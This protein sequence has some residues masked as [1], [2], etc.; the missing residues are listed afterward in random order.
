MYT[1]Q[2]DWEAHYKKVEAMIGEFAAK[3]GKVGG[4]AQ[5]LLE[6]LKL[7]DQIN[8]QLEKVAVFASLR[9]DEDM[10]VSAN[11]ALYQRMQTLRVK[12]GESASWFQPEVLKIPE[13]KLRDWLKQPDLQVYDHY[14]HDLLRSKAHILSAREEE[15]L[16]KSGRAAD[17]SSDVFGLLSNTELRWRTVKDPEGKDVDVLSLADDGV[18]L[19]GRDHEQRLGRRFRR[20]HPVVGDGEDVVARPVIV[21]DEELRAELAVRVRRVRVQSAAEPVAGGGEW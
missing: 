2:E 10:R 14:F 9:R 3:N 11:H 18:Q 8:I 19:G 17:T 16:A 4:S 5:S 15:L 13:D 6:A 12:W 20:P 21:P 7:R 1:S